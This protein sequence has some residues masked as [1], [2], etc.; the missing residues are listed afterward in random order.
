MIA[1]LTPLMVVLGQLALLLLMGV[2]F[3]ETGLLVGFFLPVVLM[4]R[5]P[6]RSIRRE[7]LLGAWRTDPRLLERLLG[8]RPSAVREL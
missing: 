5:F 2:L 6:A 4:L 3:A 8:P 7:T 1:V